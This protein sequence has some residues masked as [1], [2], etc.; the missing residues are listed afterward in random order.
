MRSLE[1]IGF[2]RAEFSKATRHRII[3]AVAQALVG[4]FAVGSVF[5]TDESM[6]VILATLGVVSLFVWVVAEVRYSGSRANAGRARRAIY[7]IGGLGHGVSPAEL[8]ALRDGFSVPSDV[9]RRQEDA[10]Y[11]L[12]KAPPG[13]QRLGEMLSESAFWSSRLQRESTVV[14]GTAFVASLALVFL[15]LSL[16]IALAQGTYQMQLARVVLAVVAVLLSTDLLGAALGHLSAWHST[17]KVVSR[18]AEAEARN[19]PPGD[20]LLAM[21]D[22]A[23]AVEAAPVAVPGLYD[24]HK[25]RIGDM[26]AEFHSARNAKTP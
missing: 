21:A 15:M 1:L 11:F 7:I 10:D 14:V 26:F 22:Y 12:S 3:M 20:V 4:L 9:A 19:Y 23:A 18:L 17:E 13:F 8:L 24:L 25:K 5:I 16:L 6:L 2:Q